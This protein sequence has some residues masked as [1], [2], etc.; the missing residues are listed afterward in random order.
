[1]RGHLGFKVKSKAFTPFAVVLVGSDGWAA[2]S[3]PP[4]A[5]SMT[6]WAVGRGGYEGTSQGDASGAGGVAWRQYG[7]TAGQQISYNTNVSRQPFPAVPNVSILGHASTNFLGSTMTAYP[8]RPPVA[9]TNA[10]GAYWGVDLTG[11]SWGS[12]SGDFSSM[13]QG[14]EA[15][16]TNTGQSYGGAIGNVDRSNG[17]FLTN[18]TPAGNAVASLKAAVALAGYKTVEDDDPPSPAFGSGAYYSSSG[19]G[20]NSDCLIAGIGGGV[21]G[22]GFNSPGIS[23]VVL[24]FE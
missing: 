4:G 16:T 12:A 21:A 15:L 20:G 19:Y 8:G 1:M 5:Q 13:S 6:A 11:Y 14:G 7:V 22:C 17:Y 23:C 10:E 18:R 24:Y 9:S 3:V 2:Y